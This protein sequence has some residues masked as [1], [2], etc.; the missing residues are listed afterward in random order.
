[1]ESLC[2]VCELAPGARRAMGCVVTL[3]GV[4][5]C[6]LGWGLIATPAAG[7]V[8]GVVHRAILLVT[9]LRSFVLAECCE[10]NR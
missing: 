2:I 5:A 7:K 9:S 1:M 8:S 6:R 10:N 3:H 4:R